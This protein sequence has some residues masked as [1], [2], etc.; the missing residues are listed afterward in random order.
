[1]FGYCENLETAPDLPA[2]DL[3]QSC[4]YDMFNECKNLVTGP[5]ISA[6]KM[7]KFSCQW[8]LVNCPKLSSVTLLTPSDQMNAESALMRWLE[9][10]GTSATTRTLVVKDK[11]AYDELNSKSYLP[12]QWQISS[13]CTVLD[14]RGNKITE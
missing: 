11:A 7:S 9:N 12:S 4:Y 14:E 5:K 8:M 6:T 1:M 2:K 13:S 3:P 10:S